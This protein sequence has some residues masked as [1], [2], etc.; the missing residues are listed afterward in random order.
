M[1]SLLNIQPRESLQMGK[2]LVSKPAEERERWKNSLWHISDRYSSHPNICISYVLE[3]NRSPRFWGLCWRPCA[4]P[5]T[6]LWVWMLNFSNL[7]HCSL[8]K[9]THKCLYWL[10]KFQGITGI[11][12]GK[13]LRRRWLK[14]FI[15][16]FFKQDFKQIFVSHGKSMN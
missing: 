12:L 15:L 10:D 7:H 4:A 9:H 1:S 16:L 8:Y 14:D 11:Y 2:I 6:S 5:R 3:M 13:H